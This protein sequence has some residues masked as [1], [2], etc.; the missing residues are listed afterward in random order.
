[1]A[2]DERRKKYTIRPSYLYQA[3]HMNDVFLNLGF[4]YKGKIL[5]KGTS[6]EIWNNPLQISLYG[7]LE[8]MLYNLIEYVKM[9][10]KWFSIAHDKNTT[11]IS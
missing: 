4:G 2:T 8:S 5:R 9:I 3:K 6:P 1:M 7:A 10:K 11:N